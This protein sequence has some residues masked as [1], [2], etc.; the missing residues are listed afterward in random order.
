M[1]LKNAMDAT[2]D[3][4]SSQSRDS[5]ATL[6]REP[7]MRRLWVAQAFS[8]AG[9]ALATVAMPLLV[10]QMTESARLVG[11]IALVLILPRVLLAPITGLLADRVNRRRLMI[12]ADV[13]R[14]GF[15][16]LV[17]FSTEIWQLAV[18]AVGLAIGNATAR[19]AE[20]A[21]VPSVAG[22]R[23]LVAALSLVQVTTAVIRIV[24]PAVGAAIISTLGAGPVFWV[25]ALCY[26][27][28]LLALRLLVVP[29][30]NRPDDA[31]APVGLSMVQTARREMWVGLKA[32]GSMPIVRG[33]TA[34]ESLW[35]L[36]PGAMVVAGVVYT[37][38]TL[39]LGDGADAAFALLTTFMA[40]GA[41]VGALVA[42]R[43]ERRIGRPMLLAIGYTGPFFMVTGL[44]SPAM[45]IMYAAFFG[46]GFTDA[47]A[48]ISFQ[49]YLAEVVPEHLRGRVFAAWGAIVALAAAFAYYAMGFVTTWIGAP[50]TFGLVGLV[51]GL[52]GPLLLWVTG[53]IRAVRAHPVLAE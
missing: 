51:V 18:L 35:A 27:G 41:V 37:Q 32:V 13:W 38:E 2:V 17:P 12:A 19:P 47:W 40:A 23:R 34:T 48:V 28:S 6:L 30:F 42:N 4:A 9:E 46:L 45:P 43:V 21:T 11:F 44:F 25:Q 26:I 31:D 24:G 14:L 5:F 7:N 1:S 22:P 3:G 15:A 16:A 20:L 36:V 50:A 33:V 10:Y 53:A 8:S 29:D 39:D 49:S 52:G